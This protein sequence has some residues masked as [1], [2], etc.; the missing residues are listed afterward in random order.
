MNWVLHV[1]LYVILNRGTKED[2]FVLFI[3]HVNVFGT[4]RLWH[5]KL[6]VNTCECVAIS[7]K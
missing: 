6:V 5:Y 7:S 3:E 1:L 4:D 2:G